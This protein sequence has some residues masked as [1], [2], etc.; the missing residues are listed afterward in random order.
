[1][2]RT[3]PTTSPNHAADQTTGELNLSRFSTIIHVLSHNNNSP[4]AFAA[5][6]PTTSSARGIQQIFQKFRPRPFQPLIGTTGSNHPS[7]EIPPA[8]ARL[9]GEKVAEKLRTAE[10]GANK[11]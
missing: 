8:E 9:A 3:S 11:E 7:V 4:A 10:R 2:L 6:P 5:F 1:M